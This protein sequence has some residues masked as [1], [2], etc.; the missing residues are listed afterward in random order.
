[1]ETASNVSAVEALP[2]HSFLPSA[3]YRLNQT[4]VNLDVYERVDVNTFITSILG[5]QRCDA[6]LEGISALLIVFIHSLIFVVCRRGYKFH[7][8]SNKGTR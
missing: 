5:W 2:L 3:L 4:S 7:V 1:M 8:A 6:Y